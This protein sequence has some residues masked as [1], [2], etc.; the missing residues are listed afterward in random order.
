M[1][2][3]S[4]PYVYKDGKEERWALARRL[5][6]KVTK[7]LHDL[8]RKAIE[9]SEQTALIEATTMVQIGIRYIQEIKDRNEALWW[10]SDSFE[11]ADMLSVTPEIIVT[12]RTP[13]YWAERLAKAGM[14]VDVDEIR[15]RAEAQHKFYDVAGHMLL[16][17]RQLDQIFEKQPPSLRS[18]IEER[19][20]QRVL[21]R[22][23]KPRRR[24]TQKR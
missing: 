20:F 2:E 17:P 15:S 10:I 6:P 16:L 14:P 3:A 18:P 5:G 1:A 12:G 19:E 8:R 13:E 24:R 23:T 21:A 9:T 4:H 22:L 7:G 11:R